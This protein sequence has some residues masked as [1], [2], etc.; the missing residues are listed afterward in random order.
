[1]LHPGTIRAQVESYIRESLPGGQ[2]ASKQEAE[3]SLME[4]R[5][6]AAVAGFGGVQVW[7]LRLLWQMHRG[8]AGRAAVRRLMRG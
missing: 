6:V 4:W 8:M 5:E 7:M 3:M 2:I 1:M